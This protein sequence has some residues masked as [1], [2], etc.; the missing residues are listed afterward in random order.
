MLGQYDS[1]MIVH[2]RGVAISFPNSEK[3]HKW[4]HLTQLCIGI[5]EGVLG[6]PKNTLLGVEKVFSCYFSM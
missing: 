3:K 2:I 5:A 6:V 4:I 1:Y